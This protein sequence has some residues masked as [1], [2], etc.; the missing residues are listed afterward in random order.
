MVYEGMLKIKKKLEEKIKLVE[1]QIKKL[2]EG[3]IV[4]TKN[5][6][7]YKWYHSDK[8]SFNYIN[9]KDRDL[10]ERLSIKKYYCMLLEDYQKELKAVKMII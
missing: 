2:P 1:L 9:K 8:N 10:A 3:K 6:K 4:C 5:G 7:G